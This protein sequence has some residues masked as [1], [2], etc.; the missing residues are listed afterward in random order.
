MFPGLGLYP[1]GSSTTSRN[2]RL[3]IYSKW[4]KSWYVRRE[5]FQS[6]SCLRSDWCAKQS[7]GC[8]RSRICP[9]VVESWPNQVDPGFFAWSFRFQGWLPRW[10]CTQRGGLPRARIPSGFGAGGL[11]QSST[12]VLHIFLVC[13]IR[14]CAS[15]V[16]E[17]QRWSLINIPRRRTQPREVLS[18]SVNENYYVRKV[19]FFFC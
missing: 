7:L 15:M 14:H 1:Y 19:K 17:L 6:Y 13:A 18:G 11:I 4:S 3:E 8:L 2:G 16:D 9:V 12:Y 5:K 10:A